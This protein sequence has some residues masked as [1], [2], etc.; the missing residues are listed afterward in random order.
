MD[1]PTR[2]LR[3]PTPWSL[4]AVSLLALGCRTAAQSSNTGDDAA[5]QAPDSVSEDVVGTDAI[6]PE[7]DAAV[8]LDASAM[9]AVAPVDAP[10]PGDVPVDLGRADVRRDAGPSCVCPTLPATCMAPAIDSP[11]F[12]PERALLDQL[13]GVVSCAET[14]LHIALYETLWDCLP[15][16]LR[17]RLEAAPGLSLQIVVDNADCPA[18]DGGAACPIRLLEGHPRVTIVSDDRSALMHHKFIVADGNRLWVASANSS[19]R[20]YCEDANDAIVVAEA[21]IVAAFEAEFQRMFTDRAF[22]PT[23]PTAPATSGI[24]ASYFSPRTPATGPSRWFTDMISAIETSRSSVDFIIAS[25]TRTE[26]SDAMLAARA[27]GVRVRGIVAPNY[28]NDA[29]AT[30][31]RAA[32][33]PVRVGNVHSKLLVV[34]DEVVV[35]GS[36]NWSASAWANNENSLWI[37][38]ANIGSTY[39]T[40]FSRE[41]ERASIPVADRDR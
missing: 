41:F 30:A 6:A 28:L 27:R 4:F 7:T 23:A 2:M 18:S 19:Q 31:L 26:V 1:Y 40:F 8:D 38:D 21:P 32:G 22:G 17:A 16:I 24:Y 3:R 9:D 34:D 14:S 15:N 13:V 11:A 10:A 39:A 37:R 20:S 36:A 5:A 25:W 29:P 33:V 35:T 12:S